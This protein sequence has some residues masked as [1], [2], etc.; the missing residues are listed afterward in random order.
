MSQNSIYQKF[1]HKMRS[2]SIVAIGTVTIGLL[3]LYF[4]SPTSETWPLQCPLFKL[5]GWQ[6][7]LCGSQRAIHELMHGHIGQAW[8]YNPGLW[9]AAP[10]LTLWAIGSVIPEWNRF[11]IVAW[12]SKGWVLGATIGM[13]LLWGVVRNLI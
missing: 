11:R 7:P 6:C 3:T 12:T 4:F 8:H 13:L 10:L 5:T 2:G 9:L 1:A